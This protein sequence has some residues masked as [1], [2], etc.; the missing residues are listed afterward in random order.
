MSPELLAR[1]EEPD[2]YPDAPESV[3]I[4]QTH[5]SVVCL[6]GDFAYKLKKPVRFPFVDFSTPELREH[7]CHEEVRLN[8]RL[9]P[10][11]YLDVV[12]LYQTDNGSWSFSNAEGRIVDHAVR[13]KRLPE[14]L[15]M[16][17]RLEGRSRDARTNTDAGPHHGAISLH[18][19]PSR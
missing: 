5:L 15:L 6:A 8:Q 10:D 13:M 16:D 2:C 19:S 12:P 4:R 1:L 7:F 9:C 3:Q 14:E 11:I 17:Q 18:R